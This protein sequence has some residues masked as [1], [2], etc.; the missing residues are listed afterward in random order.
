MDGG[1]QLKVLASGRVG[2]EQCVDGL[3]GLPD[4]GVQPVY[5]RLLYPD[6]RPV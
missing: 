4:R 3:L 1:G 2:V 6:N 5:G